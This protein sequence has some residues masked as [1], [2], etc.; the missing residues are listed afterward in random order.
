MAKEPSA[1]HGKGPR[2]AVWLGTAATVV[3]LA[4]G[5][6]TLRDEIFGGDDAEPLSTTGE[7]R[8]PYFDGVA[9]HL[10]RSR[11]SIGFLQTHDGDAVRL[12]VGFQV[13]ARS[14]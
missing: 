9:S 14:N 11:D 4:T 5:I 10:E 8:V 7:K 3:A 13:G 12:Q 2:L 1:K 6:L